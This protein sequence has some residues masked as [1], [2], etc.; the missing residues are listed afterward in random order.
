MEQDA[1]QFSSPQSANCDEF[2]AP[3]MMMSSV[4]L[5]ALDLLVP[6]RLLFSGFE[7]R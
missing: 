6:L 7:N 2:C 5:Y 1:G 3:G 4:H